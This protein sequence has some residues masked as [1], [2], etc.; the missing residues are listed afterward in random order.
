MRYKTKVLA[1]RALLQYQETLNGT[2]ASHLSA[3]D[4]MAA[5]SA[6]YVKLTS[7]SKLVALETGR[8]DALRA[9]DAREYP[10]SIGGGMPD[11]ANIASCPFL[12]CVKERGWKQRKLPPREGEYDGRERRR[13]SCV[14]PDVDAG[15][16]RRKI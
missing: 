9:Y 12:F 11:A 6:A 2:G 10:I 14:T 3:F 16:K 4:R 8:W 7:W 1:L 15:G 5:L 13:S